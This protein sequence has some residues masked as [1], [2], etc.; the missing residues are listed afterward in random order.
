MVEVRLYV[1]GKELY[2]IYEGIMSRQTIAS[3]Q[4]DS[5]FLIKEV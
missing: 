4:R 3:I 1:R 5:Q 2:L